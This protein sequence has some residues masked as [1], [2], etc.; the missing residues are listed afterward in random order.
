M[1]GSPLALNTSFFLDE[2]KKVEFK[3]QIAYF[4]WER[5]KD[6]AKI[7]SLEKEYKKAEDCLVDIFKA[8][9]EENV[10]HDIMDEQTYNS[11]NVLNKMKNT[12]M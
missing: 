2:S 12:K 5:D 4:S 10:S 7:K 1:S 6:T 11:I 3:N 9:E 8:C